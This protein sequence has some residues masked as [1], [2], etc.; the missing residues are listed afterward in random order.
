MN[1]P[2]IAGAVAAGYRVFEVVR[3][4]GGVNAAVPVAADGGESRAVVLL[5]VD[6]DYRSLRRGSRRAGAVCR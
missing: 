3:V 2:E 4:S 6:S 5:G 1:S